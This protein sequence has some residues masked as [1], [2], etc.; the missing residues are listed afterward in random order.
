MITYYSDLKDLKSINNPLID[1]GVIMRHSGFFEVVKNDNIPYFG[2]SL[3][4]TLA[5]QA[6]IFCDDSSK[7]F[8]IDEGY[9]SLMLSMPFNVQKG[10]L[11]KA[12]QTKGDFMLWSVNMDQD[13][14][15]A[16]G[17]G[18]FFSDKGIE[19]RVHTSAGQYSLIDN[20]TVVVS[21][22]TFEIEFLW[23]KSGI[24]EIDESPTMLIRVNG[25][26]II[27]G[28]IPI[29]DDGQINSLFYTEIGQT[30]PSNSDVFLDKQFQI[31]DNS[32]MLN[33]LPC[34]ISR[35]ITSDQIP[36]HFK[37]SH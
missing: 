33:N 26:D 17:I 27:G 6:R 8:S 24:T 25:N 18:A 11:Y 4:K 12:K 15:G 28:V 9:V 14:I 3:K 34:C 36:Q 37:D 21:D 20:Q 22:T 16:S 35:I 5:N 13:D 7:L 29:F 2:T 23:K 31:L 30:P 32:F 19:F 10:V 1:N